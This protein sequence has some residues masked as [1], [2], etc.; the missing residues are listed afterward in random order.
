MIPTT[1]I[2]SLGINRLAPDL[3]ENRAFWARRPLSWLS[4][5]LTLSRLS[6]LSP[7]EVQ[8][9]D[10]ERRR[11]EE[12]N[13]KLRAELEAMKAKSE[14]GGEDD[15]LAAIKNVGAPRAPLREWLLDELTAAATPLYSQYVTALYACRFG[16]TLASTRLGTLAADERKRVEANRAPDVVLTTGLIADS[17]TPIKRIWARSDWPLADRIV[18][19]TSGRVIFLKTAAWVFDEAVTPGSRWAN[20]EALEYLASQLARD[21]P[22]EQRASKDY[23]GWTARAR[24]ELAKIAESDR[25]QREAAAAVL[26]LSLNARQQLFGAAEPFIVVPGTDEQKWKDVKK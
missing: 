18:A 16:R 22:I 15:P 23:R 19:D 7:V 26:S 24:E 14:R 10:R 2:F 3:S 11:L 12:E 8:M 9:T 4:K 5:L 17:G 13:A 6:V 20:P 1:G 25:K 21:V